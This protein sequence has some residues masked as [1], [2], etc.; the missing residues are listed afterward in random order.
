MSIATLFATAF[1]VGL[2][3]AMMPGPLLSATI[4]SSARRGWMAG[5]LI[6]FGHAILEL[7]LVIALMAGLSAFLTRAEVTKAI[8]LVGGLFLIY[9][10]YTMSRDARAGR[11]QLNSSRNTAS[12]SSSDMHPVLIGILL[13]LTNPYWSI[14]WATIG[15]GYLVL[16]FPFGTIGV[17]SFFSGHILSDLLWYTLISISI[18][19]GQKFIKDSYYNAVILLCG[20]FLIGMGGYFL[21]SAWLT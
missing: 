4:A 14:W 9:L 19:G 7:L 6:V 2:S 13:S 5:P 20:L 17:G 21:Y 10:G 8:A 18:A 12:K 1:M 11:I 16:A 3:G 15:L